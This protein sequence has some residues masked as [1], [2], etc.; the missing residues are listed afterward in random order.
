MEEA[1]NNKRG[2]RILVL[3]HIKIITLIGL[4]PFFNSKS[5]IGNRAYNGTAVNIPMKKERSNPLIPEASPMILII[6][7]SLSQV[8]S[9]PMQIKIGK[10]E[11]NDIARVLIIEKNSGAVVFWRINIRVVTM[12][13]A[14]T[15][16]FFFI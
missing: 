3:A 15:S 13:R 6:I 8:S 16:N 9:K 11:R 1:S 2:M 5:A 10:S 4:H 12:A 7:S 14:Y